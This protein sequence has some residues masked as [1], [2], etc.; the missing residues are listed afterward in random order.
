MIQALLTKQTLQDHVK[1]DGDKKRETL[2]I[3]YIEEEVNTC[4]RSYWD[5]LQYC[6]MSAIKTINTGSSEF[7]MQIEESIHSCP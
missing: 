3:K 2:N 1:Q 5:T 4:L 7:K 6:T